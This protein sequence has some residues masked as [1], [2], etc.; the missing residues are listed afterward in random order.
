MYRNAQTHA[1]ILSPS[2]PL[3][4]IECFVL[5]W[6]F[7]VLKLIKI[8]FHSVVDIERKGPTW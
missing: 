5:L 7:Y 1:L 2:F 3:T 4:W 8:V 6:H